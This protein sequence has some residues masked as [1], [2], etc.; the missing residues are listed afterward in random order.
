MTDISEIEDGL[1]PETLKQLRAVPITRGRPLIAV[2][3]DEVLVIFV[4]HL[5]RWMET[6]G[7]EMRLVTYQLEGSMFPLGSDEPLPFE[8]CI[9]LI[10]RFFDEQALKQKAIPGGAK[11]L[12]RLSQSAQIVILT[13][14]PRIATATRRQN[15]DALGIPY[16]LVVNQGGKGRALA[17]LAHHACAPVGFVDDSV[18]QIESVAKWLPEATRIHFAWADFIDRIFPE[19]THAT[20]RVRDWDGAVAELSR[21]LSLGETIPEA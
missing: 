4:A 1:S 19:C 8:D 12:S 2:D 16:P 13:N 18:T 10:R 14:V 20:A 9:A 7:Y 3:V 11:A 6:I 21:H 15:L 17:W 5:S